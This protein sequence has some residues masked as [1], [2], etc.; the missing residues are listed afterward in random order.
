MK[1]GSR[2]FA[3]TLL[4]AMVAGCTIHSS[5]EAAKPSCCMASEAS[6]TFTDKS[7]Y[8]TESQWA[9]YQGKQIKLGELVGRPQS[10]AMFFANCQ[11]AC[12]IIVNDMKRIEA[13]LTP[14]LRNRVG[15]RPFA[16]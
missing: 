3:V 9:T 14:E 5:N 12:P 13:A 10:V 4:V 2:V 11:F 8:Q 6:A 7:L 16:Y 1:H 15:F